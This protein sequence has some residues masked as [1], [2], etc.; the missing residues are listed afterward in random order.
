MDVCAWLF[1]CV[2]NGP[3]SEVVGSRMGRLHLGWA[4]LDQ[5]EWVAFERWRRGNAEPSDD[6]NA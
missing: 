5:I 2:L 6:E 4:S 3:L 1:F